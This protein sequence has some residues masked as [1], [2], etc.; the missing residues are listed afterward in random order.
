M[1]MIPPHARGLLRVRA[2]AADPAALFNQINTAFA[3]FKAANDKNLADIRKGLGDVVQAEKVD[4]IN[5]EITTL[6]KELDAVNARIAAGQLGAPGQIDPAKAEHRQAFNAFFRRGFDAGLRD[7]EVKAK[8]TT[9]SD[10][11]GGYLVPEELESGI[12]RVLG[13]MTAM[14]GLAT[15]RTIGAQTYKRLIGQGGVNAGWVGEEDERSTTNSPKLAGIEF[16]AHEVYAEPLAAQTML[17]DV[18]MDVEAWL[19]DEVSIAFS[20]QEGDAFINGSGVKKP[21]GLLSY[22]KVANASYAWGKIGYAATGVAAALTN[23]T[24]NGADAL[25]DLYYSLKQGY[26]VGAAWLTSDGTM[27]AIRKLKDGDGNYLFAPP[28]GPG[29]IPTVLNKPVHTDDGMPAVAAGAFP[30]AFGNFKRGYLILDRKGMRVLR[31]PYTEKPN[32]KFYTTK[33]LG[34]GIQN[35]QAIKLLKVAAS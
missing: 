1:N 18:E 26:R 3:E 29:E 5:A 20:E 32:V 11:D 21:R 28:T 4:R 22:D 12:D 6:Q 34:G 14:R 2:D 7:L 31:D 15:V 17:D 13:T 35:F 25:I 30:V 8:L 33:R 9:Q 16:T 24:H 27:G 23:E 10:P 19:K